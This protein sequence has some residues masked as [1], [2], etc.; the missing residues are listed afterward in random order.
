MSPLTSFDERFR[1]IFTV[2]SRAGRASLTEL[3]QWPASCPRHAAGAFTAL[4]GFKNHKKKK[5]HRVPGNLQFRVRKRSL[6]GAHTRSRGLARRPD[7]PQAGD[8]PSARNPGRQ[9]T[10]FPTRRTFKLH[11]SRALAKG[12]VAIRRELDGCPENGWAWV[13][14][15]GTFAVPLPFHPNDMIPGLLRMEFLTILPHP[16][17]T[18]LAIFL[19]LTAGTGPRQIDVCSY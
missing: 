14:S 12:P 1:G 3:T 17:E 15:V 13:I 2:G 4:R 8:A 16:R 10:C 5:F 7:S 19:S 9:Y 18:I 11:A 6:P